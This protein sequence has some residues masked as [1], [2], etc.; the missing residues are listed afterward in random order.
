MKIVVSLI[1]AALLT[2]AIEA[3]RIDQLI[4]LATMVGPLA[5]GEPIL[6]F[7]ACLGLCIWASFSLLPSPTSRANFD[8]EQLFR[9][10]DTLE[11]DAAPALWEKALT[12]TPQAPLHFS[13]VLKQFDRLHASAPDAPNTQ[14]V[15]AL[16]ERWKHGKL[17]QLMPPGKEAELDALLLALQQ[18]NLLFS[19]EL[20]H[21]LQRGGPQ[22]AIGIIR[23]YAG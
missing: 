12:L 5:L 10:L 17:A 6:V 3:A 4:W 21:Y 20:G 15:R 13:A 7:S 14:F 16:V 23:K 19:D 2:V 1:I 22:G 11:Q 18:R 9:A 8:F